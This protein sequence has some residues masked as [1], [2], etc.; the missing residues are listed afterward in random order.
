MTALDQATHAQINAWAYP[1]TR[2]L[3]S[4][5]DEPT[6]RAGAGEDSLYTEDGAGPFCESCWE[7]VADRGSA[8]EEAVNGSV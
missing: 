2:E 7:E 8:D 4:V 6:G 3:C 5:C 1:G